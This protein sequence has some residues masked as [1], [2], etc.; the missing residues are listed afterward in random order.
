MILI[1]DN[2]DSFTYNI[3]EYFRQLYPLQKVAVYRNN[4][5]ACDDIRRLAPR[6]IVLSPGPS[7]PKN[8]GICLQVVDEFKGKIPI[9]GVCLGHQVIGE[10][11]GGRVVRASKIVHGKTSLVQHSQK[12]IFVDL[13]SPLQFTRYHSLVIE[14]KTLPEELEVTATATDAVAG[15][16]VEL[17][18][19]S[20]SAT[21]VTSTPTSSPKVEGV[22]MGIKHRKYPIEGVQFHPESIASERGMDLLRNFIRLYVDG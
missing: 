8:A 3:V 20:S 16:S 5:L 9:L 12:G 4:I 13:P 6:G 18:V 22:I 15:A 2:F 21:A 1:I 19:T 10:S 7:Q 14:A 17:G 11:F